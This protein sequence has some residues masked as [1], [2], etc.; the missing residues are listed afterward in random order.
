MMGQVSASRR[1][2]PPGS[3]YRDLRPVVSSDEKIQLSL[4]R[5]GVFKGYRDAVA[6]M[7]FDP[8]WGAQRGERTQK[9]YEEGRILGTYARL[10]GVVIWRRSREI[11]QELI[12]LVK[13][14]QEHD[15]IG[16]APRH[17]DLA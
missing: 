10:L 14:A 12:S 11:S 17:G 7:P 15:R 13:A 2:L 8:D 5:Y 1:D 3:N 16:R 4:S 9:N 6:G